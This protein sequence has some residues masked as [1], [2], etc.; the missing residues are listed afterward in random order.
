V[1]DVKDIHLIG[2]DMMSL[3]DVANIEHCVNL[4]E[5]CIHS[6]N[7]TRFDG[8][9]LEKL[10]MLHTLNLSSNYLTSL[11]GIG[12]L[13]SL[14]S[15]DV[16]SNNLTSLSGLSGLHNLTRLTAAYNRIS[17]LDGLSRQIGKFQVRAPKLMYLDLRGNEIATPEMLIPLR[18]LSAL[19]HLILYDTP[20]AG[21]ALQL[22]NPIV[23][24]K[25]YRFFVAQMLPWLDTLDGLPLPRS[26][27]EAEAQLQQQVGRPVILPKLEPVGSR[28]PA[29]TTSQLPP[30]PNSS[31]ISSASQ[32]NTK[33]SPRIREDEVNLPAVKPSTTFVETGTP[34]I[35]RMLAIRAAR[36]RT[37]AHDFNSNPQFP[38]PRG[39][40]HHT[41]QPTTVATP[42]SGQSHQHI[43]LELGV[44]VLPSAHEVSAVGP[45]NVMF[46][47][48]QPLPTQQQPQVDAIPTPRAELISSSI[49]TA[50]E[51]PTAR[52]AIEQGATGVTA[53]EVPL[54]ARSNHSTATEPL[55]PKDLP[56]PNH[57]RSILVGQNAQLSPEEAR[58][59]DKVIQRVLGINERP[60]SQ[61]KTP[62]PEQY[63][64][65]SMFAII[66]E[67]VLDAMRSLQ[68]VSVQAGNQ[69]T[70][71]PPQMPVETMPPGEPTAEVSAEDPHEVREN[72]M[73]GDRDQDSQSATEPSCSQ[74]EHE[75]VISQFKQD[76]ENRIAQ[77]VLTLESERNSATHALTELE[78]RHQK[79]LDEVKSSLRKQHEDQLK[80]QDSLY[81]TKL[82][83]L[84]QTLEAASAKEKQDLAHRNEALQSA[85]NETKLQLQ[86]SQQKSRQLETSMNQILRR[87]AEAEAGAR[88]TVAKLEA[89][90]HRSVKAQRAA[91]EALAEE[92]RLFDAQSTDVKDLKEL[93]KVTAR[94]EAR[95]A[96]ELR[97]AQKCLLASERQC[98][99]LQQS[100]NAVMQR[101][102]AAE[103]QL[104]QMKA[105]VESI[106]S[107]SAKYRN[108]DSEIQRLNAMLD[109]AN[110]KIASLR[111]LEGQ[112]AALEAKLVKL[113]ETLNIKNM[114]LDDNVEIIESLKTAARDNAIELERLKKSEADALQNLEDVSLQNISLAKDLEAL[115]RKS[116]ENEKKYAQVAAYESQI[117]TLNKDIAALQAALA[118]KQEIADLVEKEVIDMRHLFRMKEVR[119]E[120]RL[121]SEM[122]AKQKEITE[123]SAKLEE[124]IRTQK[125]LEEQLAHTNAAKTQAEKAALDAAAR[126]AEVEAEMKSLLKAVRI[127]FGV[128][129]LSCLTLVLVVVF[130]CVYSL[131]KRA[132]PSCPYV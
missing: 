117:A 132:I 59:L 58:V 93:L 91:E 100:L 45:T 8:R 25:H 30:G 35:D 83:E 124:A 19:R 90:L 46:R 112:K 81:T 94:N 84:R 110:A 92:K 96:A 120:K 48:S 127:N 119:L 42:Q 113:E 98:E 75:A 38:I 56:S 11:E 60:S 111:Q 123:L 125:Q 74:A 2:T 87:M 64:E 36:G 77:L 41:A 69:T 51:L 40:I 28:V 53:T 95:V 1:L 62:G 27:D 130:Q 76:Y 131:P 55:T 122:E 20:R 43:T 79:E 63:Q 106:E 50:P 66:R 23:R 118:K 54:S 32:L 47:P 29:G 37:P 13:E 121:Q 39:E 108:A 7:M 88:A 109:E 61:D 89:E 105:K 68:P 129:S 80:A 101:A 67:A 115:K 52:A 72:A 33:V 70:S 71:S 102:E 57:L 18:D 10:P 73:A 44:R 128:S 49:P 99:S 16:S 114:M 5:L 17:N 12:N 34:L 15:L 103:K 4:E 82:E 24:L 78:T 86:E 9:K 3:D 26:L 65:G 31:V 21:H 97:T 116:E 22:V 6:T 14:L 107:D 126:V 104:A 85:L